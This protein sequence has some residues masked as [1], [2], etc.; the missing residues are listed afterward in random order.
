MVTDWLG[1]GIAQWQGRPVAR[2]VSDVQLRC[3]AAL[4]G[5]I[6]A[7]ESHPARSVRGP[8]GR[9]VRGPAFDAWLDDGTG[10]IRLRFTRLD[11]PGIV[12]GAVL[13]VEGTVAELSGSPGLL[14]PLYRFDQARSSTS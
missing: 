1:D 4:V 5:V 3:R 9:G 2:R 10:T 13:C 6:R 11:V 7:V 8:A 12:P 14:N